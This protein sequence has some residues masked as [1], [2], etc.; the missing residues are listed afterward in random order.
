MHIYSPGGKVELV[1]FLYRKLN[2]QVKYGLIISFACLAIYPA[3]YLLSLLLFTTFPIL[4]KI[5][6][7]PLHGSVQYVIAVMT[8]IISEILIIKRS[9]IKKIK[10]DRIFESK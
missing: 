8:L 3:L 4:F 2:N 10:D 1:I 5:F 7:N 9:K 6:G